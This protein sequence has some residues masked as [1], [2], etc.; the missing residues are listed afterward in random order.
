MLNKFEAELKSAILLQTIKKEDFFDAPLRHGY[1][2]ASAGG[3]TLYLIDFIKYMHSV[4]KHVIKGISLISEKE[5]D[6]NPSKVSIRRS[7]EATGKMSESIEN[8]IDTGRS[9]SMDQ[10]T[11]YLGNKEY[12]DFKY[13]KLVVKR[14]T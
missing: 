14:K 12:C 7:E 11:L 2:V 1:I 5:Y 4:E 6:L 8:L 9:L 10:I 13:K 3:S